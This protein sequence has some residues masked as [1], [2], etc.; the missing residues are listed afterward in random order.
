MNSV[1]VG[2]CFN[3]FYFI[4]PFGIFRLMSVKRKP[5]KVGLARTI[6]LGVKKA[7]RHRGVDALL[8]VHSVQAGHDLGIWKADFGWVLESNQE[9]IQLFEHLGGRVYRRYRIYERPIT[10]PEEGPASGE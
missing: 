1:C 7:H 6:T 9:A 2:S 5:A 10:R 4:F 8:S 3:K